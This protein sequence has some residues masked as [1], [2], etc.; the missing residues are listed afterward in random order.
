MA[1]NTAH[2][3]CTNVCGTN[4]HILARW[5]SLNTKRKIVGFSAVDTH[6]NQNIRARYLKDGRI[7]WVGP[8]ANVIDTSQVKWW[9]KWLL[10][11]PD[12][13]G[14]IFKWMIDTYNEGFNYITN[15]VLAKYLIRIFP[16]PSPEKRPFVHRLS[17]FGRCQRIYV[18]FQK[19]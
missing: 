19:S 14:W 5:D 13:N 18:L 11:K 15:Y 2:G 17:A 6:E 8:N 16:G 12:T 7:E 1:T 9:N 10:R 3:Q 4:C